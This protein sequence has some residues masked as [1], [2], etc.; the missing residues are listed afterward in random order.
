MVC[1]LLLLQYA[2]RRKPFILAWAAG[3]LMLTPAYLVLSPAYSSLRMTNAAIGVSQFLR[4]CSAIIFFW[5]A[6]LY[7]QTGLLK[8]QVFKVLAPTALWFVLAPVALGS[9]AVLAPGFMV[10]A[11]LLGGAAAMYAAI[12]I[13]RR[14][15][16]AGL[17]GLVLL[18]LAITN[19]AAA[20]ANVG[21]PG[22][23]GASSDI[24]LVTVVLAVLAAVG[25]HLLVFE[26]MNYDLRM[27]NRRLENAREELML[28][29][30]TDP[31]TGL[32]NR[33]FLEQ[34]M[35]REL[36]RH[37]RF[38]LPLSLLFIDVD[39]FKAVNDTLGH[40]AGDGVLRYVSAFLTRHIRE[41]DYVFRWGGD[42]FLVLITCV[43]EEAERKAAALKKAFDAA[44]EAV[45]LPPGIGLSVGS[46][47]VPAGTLDL[48]PIIAEADARMY[49]DK[50]G[51]R[52][53]QLPKQPAA[54]P[55]RRSK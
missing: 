27:M 20:L 4:I 9:R 32:H 51:S 41:A 30:T 16:G 37:A 21:L 17:T 1:G 49:Q 36:Q 54:A 28:A 24:F 47:E 5:S 43:G 22:S 53:S 55:R 6:D 35:D 25:I 12:L 31:L 3:W 2:H 8:P 13:E 44:P 38:G 11:V 14:M 50:A 34:V 40:D 42:E 45:D 48:L 39:R 7:R 10:N 46:V 23:A 15:V 26:D 19:I 29:A 52:P 18:G 33:R